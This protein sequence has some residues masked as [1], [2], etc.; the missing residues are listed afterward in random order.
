MKFYGTAHNAKTKLDLEVKKHMKSL[1]A[2]NKGRITWGRWFLDE[3][4]G[5]LK[6]PFTP[7]FE[8]EIDLATCQ[9][10]RRR[11]LWLDHMAEK[12]R[13]IT[14]RDID[15][16]AAAFGDLLREGLIS[17]REAGQP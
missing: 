14:S 9:T 13:F 1:K 15:D 3:K 6:I 5:C 7:N 16:L 11:E 2:K 4:T 12:Q 10:A 8:Y 17:L